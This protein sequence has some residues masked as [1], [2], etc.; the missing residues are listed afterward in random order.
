MCC[1]RAVLGLLLPCC[2]MHQGAHVVLDPLLMVTMRY[3]C[4]SPWH[5][6]DSPWHA[7]VVRGC[8][9]VLVCILGL[10][11]GISSSCKSSRSVEHAGTKSCCFVD[12]GAACTVM[13]SCVPPPSPALHS[14]V[15]A[16][17]VWASCWGRQPEDCEQE[18]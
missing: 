5:S 1:V 13:Q 11:Y 10:R 14:K 4:L 6:C 16:K 9:C 12:L 3:L 18:H 7:Q 15:R 8:A 17:G 2:C